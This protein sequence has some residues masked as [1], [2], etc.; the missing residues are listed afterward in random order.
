MPAG[1]TKKER[2]SFEMPSPR[3]TPKPDKP[4]PPAKQKPPKK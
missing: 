1:Q 2:E 4:T 3:S